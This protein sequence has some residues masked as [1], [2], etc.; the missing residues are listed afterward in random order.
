MCYAYNQWINKQQKCLMKYLIFFK[1][2]TLQLGEEKNATE[3]KRREFGKNR[4]FRKLQSRMSGR[5][6]EVV[7][8]GKKN[9]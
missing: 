7:V 8:K 1:S 3:R 5:K 6:K 2:L 4:A 9:E